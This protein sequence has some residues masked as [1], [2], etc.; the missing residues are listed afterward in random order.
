MLLAV[1]NLYGLYCVKPEATLAMISV[2]LFPVF[3]DEAVRLVTAVAVAL[4]DTCQFPVIAADGD[5]RISTGNHNIKSTLVVD[6][7]MPAKTGSYACV[8]P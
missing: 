8:P 3:P 7:P 1:S 5:V 4:S 2:L 6:C